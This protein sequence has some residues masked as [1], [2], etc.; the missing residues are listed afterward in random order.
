L[1]SEDEISGKNRS[2]AFSDQALA[3]DD[4]GDAHAMQIESGIAAS[5]AAANDHDICCQYAHRIF[6]PP[7][8]K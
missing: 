6:E 1:P 2:P 5:R 7:S 8:L 3:D 4:R